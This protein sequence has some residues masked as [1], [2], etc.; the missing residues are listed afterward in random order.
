MFT[1]IVEAAGRVLAFEQQER[2]RRLEVEAEAVAAGVAAGDSV[3]VNGCC[4]TAVVIGPRRLGF[5]LLEETCRLTNLG[6]I[7]PGDRVNLERS[8]RFDGRVGG[9]FVTGHI[10]GPGRIEVIEPRGAD[11]I[12]KVKVPAEFGRYLVY[13]GCVAID[14]IS[15]TVAEAGEDWFSVWLIPHTLEVTNLGERKAGD[16]VNLEFDILAKYAEKLLAVRR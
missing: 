12:V 7:R 13:K 16:A 5:D 11:T 1:G 2:A 6:G 8:L 14:G 15:L 10:D 9:H 3:A 4:L